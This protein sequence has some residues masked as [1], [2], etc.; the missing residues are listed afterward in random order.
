MGGTKRRLLTVLIG[1]GVS[2]TG[3]AQEPVAAAELLVEE[4]FE[5]HVGDR[6]FVSAD[7]ID[8]ESA[9]WLPA[10]DVSGEELDRI[11]VYWKRIELVGDGGHVVVESYDCRVDVYLD[12]ELLR[13]VGTPY[14][15]RI[16]YQY[17]QLPDSS[18]LETVYFRVFSNPLAGEEIYYVDAPNV[19][20]IVGRLSLIY[21]VRD[22][23][24]YLFAAFAIAVGCTMATIFWIRFR[25]RENYL[26]WFGLFSF[27]YAVY[28]IFERDAINVLVPISPVVDFYLPLFAQDLMPL[29]LLLF[30][31][32]FADNRWRMLFRILAFG[33][34]VVLLSRFLVMASGNFSEWSDQLS[35][36][37]PVVLLVTVAAHLYSGRHQNPYV[38]FFTAA[39]AVLGAS[40]ALQFVGEAFDAFGD[41]PFTAGSMVFFLILASLPVVSYFRQQTHIIAQNVAFSRFV[42]SEFLSFIDRDDVTEVALGD[43]VERE[44]T[45]LFTDI[46]SFTTIS[47]TMSP[48]ENMAFINRY[49]A[50]MGPIVRRCHGFVDKYIGDAVMALFPNDPID[51]V[52]CGEQMLV[53]L[54]ELNGEATG[55][56]VPVLSIGIGIHTGVTMLGIVGERERFQ[57]T[58]ISD[59]VNLASRL[60]ALTKTFGH[61][62]LLSERTAQLVQDRISVARVGET[63]VKGRTQPT[64]VYALA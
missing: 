22:L 44:L 29:M 24:A 32:T 1:V 8:V 9:A 51:A 28:T 31:L 37:F 63:T 54:K 34:I 45:I 27:S 18:E 43:Q 6:P 62:L 26:L 30:Y 39:F 42:P 3:F 16:S 41:I 53:R 13:P 64:T 36:F 23:P 52:R 7:T 4:M 5:F 47:E 35:F 48:D 46:R 17:Y 15:G 40:Y 60:E 57:G 11:D 33:Q 59:A 55:V 38:G 56:S 20:T 10:D 14:P 12:A 19:G 61:P 21:L 49:L 50:A 25:R 2:I 58:V